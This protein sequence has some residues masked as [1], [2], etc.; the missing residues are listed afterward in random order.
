MAM[1]KK[2]FA[3]KLLFWLLPWPIS[4]S[5]PRSLRIYY[6]GP[7]GGPPPGF[8]DYW[9]QPGAFWPDMYTPPPPDQF[10]DIPDGPTNPSDP[11]VPGMTPP[12]YYPGPG[13]ADVFFDENYWEPANANISWEAGHWHATFPFGDPN[14]N[15]IPVG[16]WA[17]GYRPAYIH[18]S[19]SGNP[20]DQIHFKLWDTEDNM[21]AWENDVEKDFYMA[22]TYAP[23]DFDIELLHFE[24]RIDP[25]EPININL[26]EFL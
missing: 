18:I 1:S 5:L 21:I 20:A 25:E 11:Y 6:F 7:S 15:L 26:I 22:I 14:N 16:T 17:V 3:I 10:P 2:D 23:G 19:W 8:Y 9:G 13:K 12:H 24:S 4:R